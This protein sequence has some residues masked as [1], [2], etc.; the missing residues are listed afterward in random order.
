[1]RVI[2]GTASLGSIWAVFLLPLVFGVPTEEP[3]FGESVASHLPKN[4][5]RCCDPEDPLSPADT[6][7]AVPPYV[8]P[9][10]RPYINITILKGDKGDRGPS[11]TPGKPGSS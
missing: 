4:C 1:M 3:T 11:G 6:V 2:M 9:E 8:L 7:N 5:Q 10:V